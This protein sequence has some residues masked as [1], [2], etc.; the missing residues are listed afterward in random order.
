MNA[1][2]TFVLKEASED[3]LEDASDI[4]QRSHQQFRALV[5]NNVQTTPGFSSSTANVPGASN[6]SGYSTRHPT[7][8]SATPNTSYFNG[9]QGTTF[10]GTQ[11]FCVGSSMNLHAT[12]SNIYIIAIA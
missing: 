1:V 9:S 2:N 7:P 5:I 12:N 8:G 4:Y 6:Q 11:S 3:K 10:L